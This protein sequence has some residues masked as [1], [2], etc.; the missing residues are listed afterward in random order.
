MILNI[1][2]GVDHH[3]SRVFAIGGQDEKHPHSPFPTT[4]LTL[5]LHPMRNEAKS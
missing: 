5:T 4:T 1:W 2:I 3:G